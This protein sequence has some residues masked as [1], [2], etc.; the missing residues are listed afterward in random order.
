[1]DFKSLSKSQLLQ[2]LSYYLGFIGLGLVM[3][4]AGPH[5]QNLLQHTNSNMDEFGIVF[6]FGS[7]GFLI[8][9]FTGGLLFDRFKGHYII[10][11]C[12]T[13][14]GFSMALMP[15]IPSIWLMGGV[16]LTNGFAMSLVDMGSN[17]LL[18]WVHGE[19][20]APFMNALHLAFGIGAAISP[21]LI[22]MFITSTGDIYWSYWTLAFCMVPLVILFLS[23]QSPEIRKSEDASENELASQ[24][25]GKK[26]RVTLVILLVSFFFFYV[27]AEAN[28]GNYIT[29][30]VQKSGL[31]I[32]DETAY[33]INSLFFGTFTFGRLIAIPVTA[34]LKTRQ[35]ITI[36]LIGSV[37]AFVIMLSFPNSIVALGIGSALAG[38]SM[39]S[40]FPTMLTYAEQNLRL[41]A[42]ITSYFYLG[43][44]SA[45][46]VVSWLIAQ[47]FERSGPFSFVVIL[48]ILVFMQVVLWSGIARVTMKPK[49]A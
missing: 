12:F 11:A 18:T 43:I 34:R 17:T 26:A 45:N 38:L 10:A 25:N 46:M 5:L 4:S 1:V 13:L 24:V 31:A 3:V 42:R 30:Y 6:V 47:L 39:A 20:S 35:T 48:T 21:I 40:V 32:R 49:T 44:S 22:G 36:D 23:V 33:L 29:S 2:T 16:V 8:G 27:G 37:T 15:L 7:I 41:T 19:K 9:S 28:F 14:M